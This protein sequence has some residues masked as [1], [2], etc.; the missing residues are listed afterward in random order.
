[1]DGSTDARAEPPERGSDSS[2]S[3]NIPC[4]ESRTAH[5]KQI[6]VVAVVRPQ[7][8]QRDECSP[9]NSFV[10]VGHST[11]SGGVA[12]GTDVDTRDEERARELLSGIHHPYH[13]VYSFTAEGVMGFREI[14]PLS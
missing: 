11:S 8:F 13:L 4:E 14:K 3:V 2:S 9:M 5:R 6:R 1:M 10:N 12:S 7:P